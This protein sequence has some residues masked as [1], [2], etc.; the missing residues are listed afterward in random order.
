MK[1]NDKALEDFNL[2]CELAEK[3]DVPLPSNTIEDEKLA[4]PANNPLSKAYFYKAKAL[5]KLNNFNDA[6]LYFE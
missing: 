5:K 6:I 1:V 3:D 2:L 4:P